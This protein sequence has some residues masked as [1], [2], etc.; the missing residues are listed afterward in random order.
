MRLWVG[1]FLD[2]EDV[3]SP[4]DIASCLR[5][6]ENIRR[7]PRKNSCRRIYARQR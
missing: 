3:H 7:G 6:F 5:H 2:A 4:K 1:D